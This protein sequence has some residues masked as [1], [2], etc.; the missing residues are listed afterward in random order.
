MAT[1]PTPTVIDVETDDQQ[2][3]G[4]QPATA[5]ASEPAAAGS[6][7][8]SDNAP[9]VPRPIISNV[10]DPGIDFETDPAKVAAGLSPEKAKEMT[11]LVNCHVVE[12]F[13]GRT[14]GRNG[15]YQS[16]RFTRHEVVILPKWFALSHPTRLVIKE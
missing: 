12:S 2:R 13:A 16:F 5:P 10:R 4:A 11:K 6:K 3:K 9:R 15:V 7:P 1:K 14:P 8:A